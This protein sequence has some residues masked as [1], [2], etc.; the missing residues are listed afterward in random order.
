M[1]AAPLQSLIAG[2]WVGTRAA[3]AL[4]SA[5]D[6]SVVAYTHDDALDFGERA[7]TSA[8]R[9]G[10]KAL[11]ALDFQQ[12]A[13][14]LKAL[15]AYLNERKEAALRDVAPHRR[16]AQRQLDRHRG[17]HR[18]ALRLRVASAANELPSGNVV[19]EG[20][21][22]PLGKKGQ[23]RRHPH[24]GAARRR[25]GPHQRVQLPGLG[26]AREVRAELPRR[27]CRASSSRRRRPATSPRRWCG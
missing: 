15:A 12:R 11:M 18:H 8:R 2:D 20:P 17:R 25:R 1:S 27:R 16:D 4:P 21:V 13:A 22:V 3:L 10:F 24:P 14:R 23:L 7:A 26:A 19:H 9:Q 5:I 6:G